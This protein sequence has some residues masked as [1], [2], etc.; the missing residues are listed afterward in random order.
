MTEGRKAGSQAGKAIIPQAKWIIPLTPAEDEP[1]AWLD[2]RERVR[3]VSL[4]VSVIRMDAGFLWVAS[5]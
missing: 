3:P 4:G 5:I 1:S 2:G